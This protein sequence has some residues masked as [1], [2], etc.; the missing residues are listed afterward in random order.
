MPSSG[1]FSGSIRNGGYTLR[2]EWSSSQSTENNTST[3]TCEMYLDQKRDYGLSISSRSNSTTIDGTTISYTSAAINN[4]G[5][6]TVHLG[7]VTRT[8]SH[9]S[10]GTKGLY[11]SSVF[12]INATLG[13]TRYNTI[14]AS[15]DWITLPTIPRA[16][17]V[18]CASSANVGGSLTINI[19]R[20]SDSFLHVLYYSVGGSSGTI[21]SDIATS[22]TWS[23]P[24][25]LAVYITGQSG[26]VCT[27][28][29]TTFSGGS[30]IGATS[31]SCTLNVPN[32]AAFQPEV[33]SVVL[34]DP[35]GYQTTY[36]AYV[37]GMSKIRVQTAASGAYGSTITSYN[38]SVNNETGGSADYTS[39]L[40]SSTCPSS[41]T[42]TIRDSRGRT[43]SKTESGLTFLDYAVP[44]VSGLTARRVSDSSGTTEDDEG[45]FAKISF[46]YTFSSLGGKNSKSLSL[47]SKSNTAS[48]YT[49]LET[50]VPSGY[51]GTYT[52]VVS[53]SADNAYSYRITLTDDLS[54]PVTYID[55]S[56]AETVFDVLGDGTGIAFG[57]VASRSNALDCDW[58]A[59]FGGMVYIGE[60]LVL[61][62]GANSNGNWMKFYD[63]TLICWMTKDFGLD[64]V[65]NPWGVLFDG[66]EH[67]FPDFPVPFVSKP[68]MLLCPEIPPAKASFMVEG[69]KEVTAVSPGVFWASRPSSVENQ[70]VV[71]SYMAIGRWK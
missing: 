70:N 7:T 64:N 26:A 44:S 5:N 37:R 11:L 22:Y 42:A 67:R 28:T 54:A 21:A 29:C 50:I 2:V 16:S 6:T 66:S 27:I 60:N 56:T 57:K 43:A 12:N 14:E 3:I 4:S 23:I 18:S 8:V 47:A 69:P 41:V 31:T 25:A 17:S 1:S 62:S 35:T 40:V 68:T 15:S 61:S 52:K 45:N 32:T 9:N 10:D 59:Y 49:D 19:S 71:A 55:L 58:D 36:G 24:A 38:V 48:S 34:S 53:A 20:A 46:T 65:T 39:G 33:S 63:G 51:S 30:W 13:G